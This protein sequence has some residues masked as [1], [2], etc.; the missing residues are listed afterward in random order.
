MPF[1]FPSH[2]LQEIVRAEKVIRSGQRTV[3]EAEGSKGKKLSVDLDL[4]DGPLMNLKLIIHCF[5]ATNPQSYR[6]ALVLEGERIRGV[7]YSAVARKKFFKEFIPKGWHEN[8]I[9]PNLSTNDDNRNRH[10]ALEKFAP[11]DLQHFLRLV[12]ERWNIELEAAEVLL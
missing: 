8:V 5:D 9:D 4:M 3:F 11:T 10:V 1:R 6:A 7:D 2:R 12:A